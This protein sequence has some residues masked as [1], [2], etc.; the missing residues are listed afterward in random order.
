MSTNDVEKV[1]FQQDSKTFL[2][3]VL[4]LFEENSRFNDTEIV[5]E[6]G[7]VAVPSL[8]LAAISPVFKETGNLTDLGAD[9][10]ALII[11]DISVQD[12]LKFIRHLFKFDEKPS[13]DDQSSL[14]RVMAMLCV[15][16]KYSDDLFEAPPLDSLN[17]LLDKNVGS[18][19]TEEPAPPPKLPNPE[20]KADDDQY[21]IIRRKRK[22]GRKPGQ[23]KAEEGPYIKEE[24][25]ESKRKDTSYSLRTV[26]KKK[27]F[28]DEVSDDDIDLSDEEDVPVDPLSPDDDESDYEPAAVKE[29]E[30][31]S[32]GTDE[33]DLSDEEEDEEV[34][35]DLSE[36]E[37]AFKTEAKQEKLTTMFTVKVGENGEVEVID[38]EQAPKRKYRKRKRKE[39]IED[40]EGEF[41]FRRVYAEEPVSNPRSLLKSSAP[42]T[43]GH[44]VLFCSVCDT[45]CHSQT[46]LKHHV[47]KEHPGSKLFK[48]AANN[49]HKDCAKC[50]VLMKSYEKIMADDDN[51][52]M[53]QVRK[54]INQY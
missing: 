43:A 26:R 32:E 48:L 52:T 47:A 34:D 22:P 21:V 29:E 38:S 12:V 31:E 46:E 10:P 19:T 9:F 49:P 39:E 5:C 6:D 1:K 27:K 25:I 53:S 7:K 41:K 11:P 40:E 42:A 24:I 35:E 15:D 17:Y 50:Q 3:H 28:A 45:Q 44:L 4:D 37:I 8:V 20:I 14:E 16:F 51:I 36:D 13:D 33:S 2:A 54:T 30:E 18:I 23:K